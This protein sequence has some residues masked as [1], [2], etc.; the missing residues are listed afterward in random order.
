MLHRLILVV[1]IALF[2]LLALADDAQEPP[3][4][5]TARFLESRLPRNN[6]RYKTFYLALELMAGRG[7]RVIV[8]TGTARQ[9]RR[10]IGD[11]CGTMILGDWAAQHGAKVYSVDIDEQAL[12]MA[13]QALG[14]ARE[15]VELVH[16]DSVEFL[17]NFNQ[18]IDFLYLD[19]YDFEV[20]NPYA[21]QRHHLNEITAA[22]P[23]LHQKSVVMID[24]C[25]LP[26][27]GKGRLVIQYL[28][29]KGWKLVGKGY[30]VVLVKA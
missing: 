4:F 15:F 14:P 27:G 30:Q 3:C 22:Y 26:Y 12:L 20:S 18:T 16:N 7:A 28:R 19:S 29:K 21:S 23:W 1:L 11:G 17:R 2:P 9:G 5:D 10:D 8:E 6:C 24:D 13:E 25:G